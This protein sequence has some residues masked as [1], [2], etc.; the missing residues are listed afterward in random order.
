MLS[1]L[2]GVLAL[3]ALLPWLPDVPPSSPGGVNKATFD[4]I[5]SGMKPQEI[6]VLVGRK[7]DGVFVSP[8]RYSELELW[9]DTHLRLWVEYEPTIAN[10]KVTRAFLDDYS[11][12][13]FLEFQL[14]RVASK[15]ECATVIDQ[16]IADAQAKM[17]LDNSVAFTK[18]IP[19]PEPR[20]IAELS[21][22]YL[23]R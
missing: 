2:Y 1:M 21:Q 8:L 14:R 16:L 11:T 22:A 18:Q 9:D 17:P 23:N 15:D 10:G 19:V 5:K 4:K 12:T 13:P 7:A 20:A 3:V 6:Q